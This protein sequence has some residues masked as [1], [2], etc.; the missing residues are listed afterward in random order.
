M[1]R[2]LEGEEISVEL[3]AGSSVSYS[4]EFYPVCGSAFQNKGTINVRC[5]S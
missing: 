2:Y 5:S 1:E 4:A 3:S